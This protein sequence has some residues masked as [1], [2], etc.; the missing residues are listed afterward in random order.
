MRVIMMPT[1]QGAFSALLPLS[2]S[3]TN[4]FV[5]STIDRYKATQR[6]FRLE[7]KKDVVDIHLMEKC[8]A[9]MVEMLEQALQKSN[10]ISVGK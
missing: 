2:A 4:P 8:F 6:L 7:C 3:S 1:K 9:E 5:A 10:L